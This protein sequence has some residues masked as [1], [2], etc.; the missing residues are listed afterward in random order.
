MG[1]TLLSK[2]GRLSSV[3][4]LLLRRL[5][6]RRLSVIGPGM[7]RDEK[8]RPLGKNHDVRSTHPGPGRPP[9]E[10][11]REWERGST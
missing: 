8:Q 10:R 4:L 7:D 11:E 2:R 5:Q 3:F 9:M 1:Y 6:I